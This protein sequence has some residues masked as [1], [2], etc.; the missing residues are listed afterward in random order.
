M[1]RTVFTGARLLDADLAGITPGSSTI[2]VEDGRI[3][4]IVADDTAVEGAVVAGDDVVELA[5]Q[6]VVPGFVDSHVHLVWMGQ[7]L[8]SVAL[9]DAPDLATIQR[10][11]RAERE[12]IGPDATVLR[13]K[14]WLFDALDT[15]PTAAMIDEVVADIPV[16]LDSNDMHSVWVNTAALRTMGV[17]A[18]TPDPPSGRLSRLPSGEPAGMLYERAAHEI[19]WAHLAA[20]TTDRD[21][22]DAVRRA[23]EAFA[24]AGVTS[25]VDMGMDEDGWAALHTLAHESDGRLPVR[26]VAHWLIPDSGD[27]TSNRASVDRAAELSARGSTWMR[28]IGVKLVLD[29]VI[30]SCTAALRHPYANGSNAELMWDEG[31]L[32]EV[33][34]AADAARLR[35][36]IHAIGDRASDVAL[37]VIEAVVAANAPWDRRPRLEHLEIVSDD[38]PARMAALAVTASIQPVHADPAIQPN[39]RAQ[40][41]D[42][43]VERGYPWPVFGAAGAR[44]ALGTDAP[45]APHEALV[46]LHI[47]TTRESV[48]DP[49]LPANTPGSVLP[50]DQ[51]L[52]HA[53]IDSAASFAAD[54]DLGRIAPGYAADFV[55]LTDDPTSRG[56]LL[57]TAVVLTVVDGEVVHRNGAAS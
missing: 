4:R 46:N 13:G 48:I 26:V 7:S 3:A 54:G 8:A 9:T 24:A 32:R 27:S 53:T 22:V 35:L 17:D 12:R 10:R 40:L 2:V 52:R 47:A 50:I 20:T 42:E 30:D 5:G 1:T 11:L 39:W 14:G 43:R 51:A 16:F 28:V 29:G 18:E 44:V 37:D 49:A 23:L 33:V 45:T 19:G 56:T 41:G 6:V 34:L 25:V 15:E 36:A 21:R 31:R 57:G 55:V 38:T